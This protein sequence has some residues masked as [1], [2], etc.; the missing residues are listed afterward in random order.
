MSGNTPDF[1]YTKNSDRRALLLEAAQYLNNLEGHLGVG[2]S[3]NVENVVAQ[4][5]QSWADEEVGFADIPTL[6]KF[7]KEYY[8]SKSQPV[9]YSFTQ[10]TEHNDFYWLN[11]IVDLHPNSKKW[12]FNEIKLTIEFNH[13]SP[14]DGT[15]PKAYEIFPDEE[16][17]TPLQLYIQGKLSVTADAQLAIHP[18]IIGLPPGVL[19]FPFIPTLDASVGTKNNIDAG[20]ELL[21]QTLPLL[22]ID[23]V[24][25]SPPLLER[26]WWELRGREFSEKHGPIF[27]VIVQ[28]PKGTQEFKI[29]A[30]LEIARSFKYAPKSFRAAIDDLPEKMRDIIQ[31]GAT[32]E[33]E[34][35]TDNPWNLTH[36]L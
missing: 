28:M 8:I 20:I 3:A 9:P 18:P 26:V 12:A 32:L 10:L 22:K 34:T 36:F 25:H 4:E 7:T 13:Q 21:R 15:R 31:G 19:P 14:K 29:R 1:T 11:V 35:P 2:G 23:K 5:L 24:M 27:A 17:S 30:K 16:T 33:V 6:Y